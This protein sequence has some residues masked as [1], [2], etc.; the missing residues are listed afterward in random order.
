MKWSN[1]LLKSLT[2]RFSNMS[3]KPSLIGIANKIDFNE[4][5]GNKNSLP[6]NPFSRVA[7]PDQ[8]ILSIYEIF[9]KSFVFVDNPAGIYLFKVNNRNTKT[10]C[11]LCSKLTIKALVQRQ[12]SLSPA[13]FI[14]KTSDFIWSIDLHNDLNPIKNRSCGKNQEI[15]INNTNSSTHTHQSFMH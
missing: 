2:A 7:R 6:S 13:S 3:T 5:W 15:F 4:T 1:T 9:W 10:R 14:W 8:L 12:P 11:R